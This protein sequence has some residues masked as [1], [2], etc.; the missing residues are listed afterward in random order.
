LNVED[1]GG[2][3]IEEYLNIAVS[4]ASPQIYKPREGLVNGNMNKFSY[5]Q[6]QFVFEYAFDMIKKFNY[7]D[8]FIN[9]GIKDTEGTHNEF[10]NFMQEFN[11]KNH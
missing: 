4:E 8:L 2:T 1:I 11:K 7:Y 5:E 9:A 10:T 6:L 3:K